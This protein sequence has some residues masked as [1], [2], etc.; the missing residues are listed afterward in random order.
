MSH[1]DGIGQGLRGGHQRAE[2]PLVIANDATLTVLATA[3]T[4]SKVHHYAPGAPSAA[5]SA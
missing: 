3:Q 1:P 4:G 5:P 2:Q